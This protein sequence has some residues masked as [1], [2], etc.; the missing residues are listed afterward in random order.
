MW[1]R[2]ENRHRK[3]GRRRKDKIAIDMSAKQQVVLLTCG[4]RNKEGLL[5]LTVSQKQRDFNTPGRALA[6]ES[7]ARINGRS[8]RA[9]SAMD[10]L[11]LKGKTP[12]FPTDKPL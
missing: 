5:L 2:G 1:S 11:Y 10:R 7:K 9:L 8:S 12:H 4:D 6:C 3:V